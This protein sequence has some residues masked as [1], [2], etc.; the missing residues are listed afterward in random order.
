MPYT[1]NISTKIQS[2]DYDDSIEVSYPC[3]YSCENG[4]HRLKY[5][6]DE[7]GFTVVRISPDGCI[8]IRRR[9]SFTII[10]RDG[11]IHSV[12][13]ETPYGRIPMQ[14]TLVTAA[15]SLSE[16]GGTLEYTAN[17]HID[18]QLQVNR[19]TMKLIQ[20]AD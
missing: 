2:D 6:D 10:M 12:D 3:S 16:I 7:A 8:E 18:G 14:F 17:V 13:C 5:T 9:N 1:L 11:Y 4:I 20:A 15:H 19:V